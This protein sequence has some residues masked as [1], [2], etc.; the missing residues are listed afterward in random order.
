MA[1]SKPL[2][3][4]FGIR[5]RLES[6]DGVIS[7]K[8]PIKAGPHTLLCGSNSVKSSVGVAYVKISHI[9]PLND[10]SWAP[11]NFTSSANGQLTIHHTIHTIG[12]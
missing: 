9:T 10:D 4:K 6:C 7:I 5:Y 2:L 1:V 8:V 3:T 11:I 12:T